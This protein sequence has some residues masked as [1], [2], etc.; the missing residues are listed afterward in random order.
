MDSYQGLLAGGP[1]GEAV[2]ETWQCGQSKA[3]EK[4]VAGAWRGRHRT[5][6]A[7]LICS[8]PI[9]VLREGGWMEWLKAGSLAPQKRRFPRHG[10]HD[11]VLGM[12]EKRWRA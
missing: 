11:S 3:R 1:V 10:H 5:W 8:P 12:L 7:L 2:V 6:Q 4:G 9:R